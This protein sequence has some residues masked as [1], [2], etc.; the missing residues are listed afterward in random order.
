MNFS[1]PLNRNLERIASCFFL[2]IT[3]FMWICLDSRFLS[4]QQILSCAP[5]TIPMNLWLP[6]G[7]MLEGGLVYLY[8]YLTRLCRP[9]LQASCLPL[10]LQPLQ[11]CRLSPYRFPCS[12][13]PYR[14]PAALCV[15]SGSV[16]AV[17]SHTCFRK[18]PRGIPACSKISFRVD[19]LIGECLGTGTMLPLLFFP[20]H[21]AS[22]LSGERIP[23]FAQ[24]LDHVE[25]IVVSEAQLGISMTTFWS[26]L[27]FFS[28]DSMTS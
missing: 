19:S 11:A 3:A 22:P 6:T 5:I 2:S 14:R 8:P 24:H 21:V 23:K 20:N 10:V 25:P 4:M 1:L 27:V 13:S 17:Y 28:M 26:G 7:F 16:Q 12:L 9:C 15:H 18:S